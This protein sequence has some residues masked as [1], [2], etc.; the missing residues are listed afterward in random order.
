[1]GNRARLIESN[2]KIEILSE[3]LNNLQNDKAKHEAEVK[4]KTDLLDGVGKVS[5]LMSFKLAVLVN[6]AL[7]EGSYFRSQE[8]CDK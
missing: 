5:M 8:W 6:I 2:K 1:M 3:Q 4:L 7:Q